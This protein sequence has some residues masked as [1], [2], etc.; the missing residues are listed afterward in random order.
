VYRKEVKPYK[1]P[2]Q[3][4]TPSD[5]FRSLSVNPTVLELNATK[6]P[7]LREIRKDKGFDDLHHYLD[8]NFRLLKEDFTSEL[9]EGLQQYQT[10]PSH[11][12]TQVNIY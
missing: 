1:E 4:V 2:K 9:R 7:V 8:V 12:N 11:G 3:E 5:D 10:D 6:P